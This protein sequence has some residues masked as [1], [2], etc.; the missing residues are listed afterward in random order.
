ME[1]ILRKLRE[2][3]EAGRPAV[4]CRVIAA[5]G[6]VPRG[7]GAAM[8]ALADGGA[9]GTVG[10]G[11]VERQALA[12]AEELLRR[13]RSETASYT[14]APNEVR[15]I[16]MVC[17]GDVRL[18]FQYFNPRVPAHLALVSAALEAMREPVDSLLITR[19][20][21]PWQGGLWDR[22][23]GL[24][25][26]EGE[27]PLPPPRVPTLAGDLYLEPLG[28]AE[29]L[30]L[31]GAGHVG[32]ALAALLPGLGFRLVVMDSRPHVLTREN[33]PQA[34]RLILGA[35]EDFSREITVGEGDYVVVMTPGHQ[36]DYAVLRQALRTPAGYIGC[37][38]SR[39]KAALTRELLRA[40]GFS[41]GDLDRIHCPIGLAIGAETPEE[42]AVSIAAELIAH[43]RRADL[44]RD[45]ERL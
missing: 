38:G 7:A 3:L 13:G 28:R 35:Y 23:R 24:R 41:Q 8:L 9:L 1:R 2:E 10:G 40:D 6:S 44:R 27:L 16:G 26:W 14:L 12:Q 30:Y 29:T 45:L 39:R 22:E 37:I 5:R 20:G 25:F 36:G 21:D 43:R 15:D 18:F 11:A 31:V 42:I 19:L 4:L 34:S 33:L 32:L 17:G